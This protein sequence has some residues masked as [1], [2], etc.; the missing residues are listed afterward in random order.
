[1]KVHD[2]RSKAYGL[3]DGKDESTK[4][5][6]KKPKRKVIVE[7]RLKRGIDCTKLKDMRGRY[8]ARFSSWKKYG[9][10]RS[11]RAAKDAIEC[12][13]KSSWLNDLLVW[14]IKPNGKSK[15]SNVN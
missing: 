11:E 12:N 4:P 8:A 15:S 1:M 5:Y 2:R 10:Y 3:S 14:R 13:N 6:R 9:S 7:A